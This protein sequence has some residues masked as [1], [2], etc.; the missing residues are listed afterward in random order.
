MKSELRKSVN[1]LQYNAAIGK[2]NAGGGGFGNNPS[3]KKKVVESVS[4]LCC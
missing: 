1:G 3:A 4:L 2:G